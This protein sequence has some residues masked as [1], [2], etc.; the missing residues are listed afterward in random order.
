MK[1]L[2]RLVLRH[3]WRAVAVWLVALA[4]ATWPALH[5]GSV[6]QG[7]ADA[8][9][10]SE[11]DLVT[12]TIRDEFGAGTIYQA[13]VVVSSDSAGV[14]DPAFIAVAG[15]VVTALESTGRTRSVR[16]YWNTGRETLL[17]RDRKSA[18]LLVTPEVRTYFE[19]EMLTGTLRET[20]A[21][22]ALPAGFGA[23]LTGSTAMLYDLDRHSSEDLLTAERYGLP[24]TLVVLLLVFGTP[25]AALLPLVLALFAVV[26]SNAGLD[27]LSR[28]VPV[29]VFALNVVSM[30]GLGVGVDY[31]LFILSRWRRER[32]RGLP[33]REAVEAAVAGAGESVLFSGAT[34]GI[35]FLALYLVRAPFLH[36]IALGG[37]AVVLTAVAA[38][39]TLLP[40]VLLLAGRALDWPRKSAPAPAAEGPARR[41]AWSG[42]AHLVMRRPWPFIGLAVAVLAVFVVPVA[43]LQRWNIGARHLPAATEARQ[44]YDRVA[45]QFGRGWM[46]PLV[47]LVRAP[48]G[49]SVWSAPRQAAILATARAL[50]ADPRIERVEG[51]PALLESLEGLELGIEGPDD[52]PAAV[53][54]LAREMV[55]SDGRTALVL[56]LPRS[57]PESREAMALLADLRRS[58]WSGARAA[59]LEVS[60]GGATAVM[61]DFDHELL[62]SLP[63]VAFVVLALT[64]V[65]L[66]LLFRSLLIP[67]KATVLNLLS[68]LAAYGFL[69]YVFQDGVG[70][71]LIGLDPPGGLNSFIVLM[72]FTILFGLS[73]DYEVF[74]LTRVREAWRAGAD[75]RHAVAEGLEETAGVITSAAL[76]MVSIFVA[77][78]FTRLVATREFGLGLA[79]AVALDATLIR[80]VLVPALMVLAG[81]RNWWPGKRR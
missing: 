19:A 61:A 40:A 81:E 47:L 26:V 7:G 27:L 37:F 64:F 56:A 22:A 6:L 46:G 12:R 67:L 70:A 52:L 45:A 28:A 20:V 77:F 32:R 33:P 9:P 11:S 69:V 29:S 71:R 55:S 2:A 76:V 3:P 68:V 24:V 43:R 73:M 63:R 5:L 49:E 18:L 80:I 42:W 35:G 51:F 36:A 34:V 50:A 13:L 17:G 4:A 62:G 25:L 31:A 79:F 53:R 38:S 74:L 59:G 41:G 60:L 44:G 10:G 72:L 14:D 8:I 1:T 39:L 21:K 58:A 66:A 78:G 57:D 16:T 54:P 30:I 65:V 23:R 48:A 75:T 15:D